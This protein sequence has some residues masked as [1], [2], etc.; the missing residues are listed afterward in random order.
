MATVIRF[1]AC[2]QTTTAPSLCDGLST[3]TDQQQ[4]PRVGCTEA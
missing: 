2:R 4:E 1:E 3:L